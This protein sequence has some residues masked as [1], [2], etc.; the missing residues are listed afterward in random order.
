VKLHW[1]PFPTAERTHRQH[2][3]VFCNLPCSVVY[4]YGGRDC[5]SGVR[6]LHCN[7]WMPFES[8]F[9]SIIMTWL[10]FHLLN[11]LSLSAIYCD[12]DN[13]R[14]PYPRRRTETFMT[15][16]LLMLLEFYQNMKVHFVYVN[17]LYFLSLLCIRWI[18]KFTVKAFLTLKRPSL[19][20]AVGFCW[21]RT[22]GLLCMFRM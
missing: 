4:I 15:A 7:F 17:V 21:I 10:K 2:T 20:G 16:L 13:E 6:L 18:C 14:R 5:A 12:L 1:F 9:L 8:L 11:W 19:V 22:H 3:S